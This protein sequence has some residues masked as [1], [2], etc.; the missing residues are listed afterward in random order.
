MAKWPHFKSAG[1][2][3]SPRVTYA[4]TTLLNVIISFNKRN[5]WRGPLIV[6]WPKLS[7]QTGIRSKM[8]RERCDSVWNRDPSPFP[9]LVQP[10]LSAATFPTRN[11][12]AFFYRREFDWQ[13]WLIRRRST[14]SDL[15]ALPSLVLQSTPKT[16][17]RTKSSLYT[18]SVSHRKDNVRSFVKV[19]KRYQRIY[20]DHQ[21]PK[22]TSAQISNAAWYVL[23][24]LILML[25]G[26]DPLKTGYATWI[27]EKILN[28]KKVRHYSDV[29][30]ANSRQI[31]IP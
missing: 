13:V 24:M 21:T 22:T 31:T 16:S 18:F 6:T 17:K 25:D 19:S 12:L 26:L 28:L 10:F 14:S 4:Q 9:V 20:L 23:Q 2:R 15:A 5:E 3:K 29:D 30:D 8:H 27:G 11:S 7:R 1:H